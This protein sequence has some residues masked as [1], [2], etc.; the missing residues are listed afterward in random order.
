[1]VNTLVAEPVETRPP[2]HSPLR[3][4]R[5][6]LAHQ[7]RSS[8]LDLHVL[9]ERTHPSRIAETVHFDC[10]FEHGHRRV[11][12]RP[13]IHI[14]PR[15]EDAYLAAIEIHPEWMRSVM[16]NIEQ[17]FPFGQRHAPV[18]RTSSP[19]QLRLRVQVSNTAFLKCDDACLARSRA[20]RLAR[21]QRV[22]RLRVQP[23]KNEHH[24]N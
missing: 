1:M 11:A 2:V 18:R 8:K 4:R 15:T 21:E 17:Y 22:L 10:A 5:I 13:A 3:L 12:A 6:G 23:A 16:D 9:L 19:T 7:S 24:Q 14:E 20:V